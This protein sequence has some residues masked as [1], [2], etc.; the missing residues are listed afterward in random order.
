MIRGAHHILLVLCH[1]F[2]F[3]PP[4]KDRLQGGYRALFAAGS[5]L[6]VIPLPT[7]LGNG[8]V[9]NFGEFYVGQARMTGGE[10]FCFNLDS[11]PGSN[12][13]QFN[14][15]QTDLCITDGSE[16]KIFARSS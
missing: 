14:L 2:L 11:G 9:L 16:N 6:G 12:F 13:G 15:A 1:A 7:D 10:H 3:S 5:T 8:D 4:Q